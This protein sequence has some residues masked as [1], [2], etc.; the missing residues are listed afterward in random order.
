MRMTLSQSHTSNKRGNFTLEICTTNLCDLNCAYCFE[1]EKAREKEIKYDQDILFKRIDE[2][3]SDHKWFQKYYNSLNISFWGGEPTLNHAIIVEVM[4]KYS[5]HENV[6]FHIYTNGFNRSNLF[7]IVDNVDTRR[8]RI[9]VSY[10]GQPIH[11][12]YRLTKNGKK[13]ADIIINNSK[14]LAQ[15]GIDLTFKSTIPLEEISNFSSAWNDL[16]NLQEEFRKI[17]PNCIIRYAPTI[18]Q[19]VSASLLCE[20]ELIKRFRVQLLSMAKKEIDFFKQNGRFLCSWFGGGASR[21]TCTAGFNMAIIDVAGEVHACHGILYSKNKDRLPTTTIY[22]D[23]F[24]DNIAELS[25]K[26]GKILSS[27]KYNE[28]ENCVATTCMICPV[29]SL[30]VSKKASFDEQWTDRT[31]LNR[32]F[33]F[34]ALG[35]IDRAVQE[36]NFK[37]IA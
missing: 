37:E 22:D 31:C 17:N 5:S 29:N 35:E 9:Q 28:C 34:K 3:L 15:K 18:D 14:A 10:D 1:G 26:F 24:I 30:D 8:L 12:R 13:T 19:A 27:K 2:I 6:S 23:K 21:T 4:N 33:Y 32:C 11:D 16:Y 7:K 25:L 20:E 36:I